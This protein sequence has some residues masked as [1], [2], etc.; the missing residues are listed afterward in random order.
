MEVT[1]FEKCAQRCVSWLASVEIE[2]ERP[3][4]G[5]WVRQLPEEIMPLLM[6]YDSQS[7]HENGTMQP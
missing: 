5:S 2:C 3:E 1:R 6:V 7:T 4:G